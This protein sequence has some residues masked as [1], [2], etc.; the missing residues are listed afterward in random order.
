MLVQNCY[1]QV[2]ILSSLQSMLPYLHTEF[3]LS[4]LCEFENNKKKMNPFFCE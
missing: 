3:R 1:W 4:L 2:P